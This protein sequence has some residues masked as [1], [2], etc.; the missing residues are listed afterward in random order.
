M[1]ALVFAQPAVIFELG[2]KYDKSFG[3]AA[4]KGA[5]AWKKESG[6]PYLEFEIANAAQREQAARRF[7]ER[8]VL[9]PSSASA[10]RRPAASPRWRRNS[11]S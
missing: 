6:K 3:E 9:T 7:A 4:W 1:P 11:P 2:G 10:F 5:E 8:A